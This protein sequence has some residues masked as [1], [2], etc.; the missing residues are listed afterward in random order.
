M[1]K[2]SINKDSLSNL[3]NQ[4]NLKVEAIGMMTQKSYLQEVSKAAFVIVG[5]KFMKAI[6]RYSALNPKRMHHI[7]EWGKV[8][9]PTARLFV[10]ERV[11]LLGGTSVTQS[12][13]LM[14]KTPVP[15]NPELLFP[16]KTG[17][18]VSRRNIFRN[19]ASVM[20]SGVPITYQAQRMLAFMGRDGMKFIQPG[21]TINIRNPGGVATKSSFSRYMLEW[22]EKNAQL[23]MDSS[24]LY[25]RIV[26]EASV[27]LSKNNTGPADIKRSVAE[28][29]NAVSHG[30]VVIK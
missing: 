28:I 24:G 25:E 21:T 20:E 10:L 27:I 1:I 5:E 3:E 14:S 12:N 7:Y 11:A 23:I 17:K 26:N 9:N 6:D 13:F 19:K 30:R 22:Y 29:S 2:L 15:I 18:Y 16:G 8:G 4:L